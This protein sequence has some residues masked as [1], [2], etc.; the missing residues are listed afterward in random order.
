MRSIN[1]MPP[2]DYYDEEQIKIPNFMI[3]NRRPKVKRGRKIEF[4]MDAYEVITFIGI[5]V[6]IYCVGLM[7]THPV[8]AVFGIVASMIAIIIGGTHHDNY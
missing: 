6:L 5:I 2:T 8:G 4:V 3:A 7:E 1:E